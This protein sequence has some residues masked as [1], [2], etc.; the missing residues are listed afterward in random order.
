[1]PNIFQILGY[2][3]YFGSNEGTEPVYVHISKGIPNANSTKLWLTSGGGCIVSN[4]QS[5]IP[6]KDLKKIQQVVAAQH[7]F[8]VEKWME[9]FHTESVTFYC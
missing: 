4:N 9:F 7:H 8:I 1:M 6:A 5:R 3:I 2:T